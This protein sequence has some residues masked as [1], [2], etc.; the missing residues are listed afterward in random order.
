MLQ[1]KTVTLA[2]EYQYVSRQD[3]AVNSDAADFDEKWE[4]YVDGAGPPPLI[5]GA[6]PTKF[7]LRHLDTVARGKLMKYL[8]RADDDPSTRYEACVAAFAL[9][10]TGVEDCLGPDGKPLK[11]TFDIDRDGEHPVRVLSAASLKEFELGWV[12]E[13]GGFVLSRLNPGPK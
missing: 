6:V 2:E 4:Q 5:P 10:V 9:A 7:T 11:L 13:V 12:L 3:D 8:A 1:R